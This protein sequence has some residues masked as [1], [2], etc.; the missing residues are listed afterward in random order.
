MLLKDA[1]MCE[2][3]YFFHGTILSFYLSKFLKSTVVTQIRD[4]L[5]KNL[6]MHSNQTQ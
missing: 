3:Y 2:Y 5:D 6:Y 4:Q 1:F